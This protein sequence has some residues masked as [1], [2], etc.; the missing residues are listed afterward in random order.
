MN[1]ILLDLRLI[2]SSTRPIVVKRIK[3]SESSKELNL[4]LVLDIPQDTT[5]GN[6]YEEK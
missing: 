6:R 3:K 1:K 2:G 4:Q 5:R